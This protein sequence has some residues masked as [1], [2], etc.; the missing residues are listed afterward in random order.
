MREILRHHAVIATRTAG[1][2]LLECG[3]VA[4]RVEF[5]CK[6]AVLDDRFDDEIVTCRGEDGMSLRPITVQKT[7]TAPALKTGGQFPG[8]VAGV[9]E[10]RIYAIA[11]IGRVR[12]GRVTG[13][14]HPAFAI[15]VSQA[16]PQFPEADIIE[17][18]IDRRADGLF[19]KSLEIEIIAGCPCRHR[20]VEKPVA[21]EVDTA[22]ELPVAIH[23]R[24]DG[25]EDCLVAID[26]QLFI[27]LL[28]VEDKQ[29][30]QPVMRVGCLGNAGGLSD[31]R[32]GTVTADQISRRQAT[33]RLAFCFADIDRD[34]VIT[35]VERIKAP[36]RQDR[37]T[38][39]LGGAGT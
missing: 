24:I 16:E 22:K 2:G 7:V 19:Q 23:V 28:R 8:Q 25:I 15:V 33:L 26:R 4:A 20:R 17:I 13:D 1:P 10:P 27:K 31:R 6:L 12:M 35:L 3:K 37:D 21:V 5:D 11:T 34:I 30:H 14:E 18:H 29:R 38:G 32:A 9:L 36:A 39:K